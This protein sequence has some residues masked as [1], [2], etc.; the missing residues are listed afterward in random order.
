MALLKGCWDLLNHWKL[1]YWRWVG[2]ES[3]WI[4]STCLNS[5]TLATRRDLIRSKRVR[6]IHASTGRVRRQWTRREKKLWGK[7]GHV[8]W[9]NWLFRFFYLFNVL[10]SII[11][12]Q[13]IFLFFYFFTK[14]SDFFS[15]AN[16]DIDH[17]I[18]TQKQKPSFS[19]S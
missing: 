7:E 15:S 14:I 1:G 13:I 12:L 3:R 6:A 16:R 18:W 11:L 4:H 5:V 8:V 9:F 2:G 10:D 19:L 17:F